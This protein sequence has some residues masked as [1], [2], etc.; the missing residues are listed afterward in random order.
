MAKCPN[1]N[2]A[3]YKAL[4]EVYTSELET[5]NIINAWQSANSTDVFPT[6]VEAARFVSL[7]KVAFALKQRQFGES[8]IHNLRRK[9]LIHLYEGN[10]VINNSY[11]NSMVY[12]ATALAAN[13]KAVLLYLK[14]NNIPLESVNITRT[15][16]SYKIE[17]LDNVFTPKDIMESSR[18]WNTPRSREVV[19][20][21]MK[22]FPQLKVKM[23]S[24]KEAKAIHDGL[25]KWKKTSGPFSEVNSFYVDGVV[26]L[27][28]GKVTNETAI[29][30]MLHPFIDAIKVDNQALFNNLLAEAKVNFPEMAQQI[31][32][33]YNADRN[34]SQLDRDL[35]IVTQ[36]LTRHFNKEY[37]GVKPTKTF[38]N[39]IQD[40]LEWLQNVVN[41][42]HEYIAG[43]PLEVT[44]INSNATFS[45]IARLLN[46]ADLQFVLIKKASG[47]VRYSLSPEKAAIKKRTLSVANGIQTEVLN[48]MYR[49][50]EGSPKVVDSLSVSINS[51]KLK[52]GDKGSQVAMTFNAEEHTY[53]DLNSNTVYNSVTTAIKGKL[54]N[55]EGEAI[56]ARDEAIKGLKGKALAA[57]K[58]LWVEK[59]KEGKLVDK[60]KLESVQYNL[61][62]GNDV[63][64]IVEAIVIELNGREK[65]NLFEDTIPNMKV[66]TRDQ[67]LE[68]F[69]AMREVIRTLMPDGS[70]AM[71]QV[72][73][74]DEA[75]KLAGTADLLIVDKQGRISILDLKTSKNSILK[76]FPTTTKKGLQG[77]TLYEDKGWALP[78]DSLLKQKGV[79]TLS[80]KGQHNLQVNLYRRMLE[81]M[82]YTVNEGD[83]SA[84]T[85]HMHLDIEGKGK[86]QKYLGSYTNEKNMHHNNELSETK[87]SE[88][89]VYVD[90]LIPA[91]KKNTNKEKLDAKIAE[92]DE[93]FYSGKNDPLLKDEVI[94]ETV[95]AKVLT[96]K[97][98]IYDA[99]ENYSEAVR[100]A[101]E[102]DTNN[103]KKVFSSKTYEQR[104]DERANEQAYILSG[105][106]K[107]PL[108]Q[109]RVYTALLRKSLE[110]IREFTTYV[111]DP[112]NIDDPAYISYVLNFNRFLTT[113]APLFAIEDSSEL[114][115]TQ[116]QL[117]LNL[118]LETNKLVGTKA[119]NTGKEGL[120]NDAIFNYV[121]EVVRNKSNRQ[122]GVEGSGNT[123]ADLIKELT[124]VDDISGVDL[125]TRDLATS[126]DTLLAIVDKIYKRQKQILLDKINYR[127]S[128]IQKAGNKLLKLSPGTSKDQLYDFMHVFREGKRTGFYTKPIGQKYYTLRQEL[129][130]AT[131]DDKGVPLQY[132]EVGNFENATKE[133]IDY[134]IEVA[135]KKRALT[136]FSQAERS[137]EN[138][139]RIDGKYHR[140][141]QEFQDARKKFEFWQNNGTWGT[142]HKRSNV[143][144][145]KEV[146][147]QKFQAKYYNSVDYNKAIWLNGEPTGQVL[148]D[149]TG[150]IF[151]KGEYIVANEFS[152]DENGL[153]DV[154]GDMRSEQYKAIFDPTKTDA[155]SIAQREF[156]ELYVK[157]YEVELLGKLPA[158]VKAQMSGRIPT[159]KGELLSDLK[160][161]SNVFVRMY[162]NTVRSVSNLTKETAIQKNV[163]LDEQGNFVNSMPVFYTG[164]PRKE[165]ALEEAEA[166]EKALKDKYKKG[167]INGVT[168]KKE[169]ALLSGETAKLRS[170]PL[171]EELSSDLASSLI[172]FSAM[173][174]HYEVMGEI[175]DTLTAITRVVEN[176]AYEPSKASTRLVGRAANKVDQAI[177][178]TVGFKKETSGDSNTVRRLRKYLSMVYYDNELITKGAVDKI[179]DQLIGFSS[180]AYVAFNP[181]GNFN[182]Y[183][184]G[185]INNNIEMLGSRFYSKKSYF[186]AAKEY[187]AVA[188]PGIIKR[189]G[190]G[191][192]DIADIAT[193]GLANIG[194]TD[195]DP[196]QANN[197]YEALTELFRMMDDSTDIRES[198]RGK[199]DKGVWER[200]K[201][202]GYVL[203]DAA[204]YNVQTKVGIAL[205]MDTLVLNKETGETMSL[206]DAFKFNGKTHEVEL[207]DGFE[208]VIDKNGKEIAQ[209]NDDFRYKLRNNI[210]EVNKQIHGNYA[211]EDRM[212]IQSH[213]IGNLA[214]QFKKWVAP[215]V[216]A[217]FQNEYFDENLGWMEGRYK[218][219]IAFAAFAKQQ[220]VL[221]NRDFKKYGEGFL[222]EQEGYDGTGG[223]GDSRGQN[224]L[225]GVYRT[226][227]EIAIIIA[228]SGIGTILDSVL[229][230]DD[231]DSDTERRLKNLTKYQAD[232]LYKE[233]IL[234]A[235]ITP[236]SWVQIHQMI[237]SPVAASR[238]LGELGEAV[239]QSI[240]FAP[241]YLIK[242]EEGF[243]ADSDYV[244]QN[245][246]NK[247]K[248]K[249]AKAW[250]DA[251][252]ILTSFK[253]WNNALIEREF[254]Y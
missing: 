102:A 76:K 61:D 12:D 54:T 143:K 89:G 80:T 199:D 42:L 60:T 82:G 125:Q 107:G 49:I 27:I 200:F 123:E 111:S 14:A 208:T 100:R 168:Y 9:K 162:S 179:A 34:F 114:N 195:Y 63:D 192:Q 237:K 155:L 235:P 38:L 33:A 146:E 147:Y 129:M 101:Q 51:K 72:V 56:Q 180:L 127:E 116:K 172:K 215:A 198:Q 187:N 167:E 46:T 57:E 131:T 25:P 148:K 161:K 223:L 105:M 176:R 73:L 201:A 106:N 24:V 239:N 242:G 206:Y 234:F 124:Q 115:A 151:V 69:G 181:F 83:F 249:V 170:A 43:N 6:T 203:Q 15:P 197:K 227:G 226:M 230:G 248:L 74:F 191:I 189:T 194:K 138:G 28:Q 212:I 152:L 205:I 224:R 93:S 94:P 75:T 177:G 87:P 70:I 144:G 154:N 71:S 159:V 17:V 126:T 29:E 21:L 222:K 166:K 218:S 157:Y 26:Y 244:Y 153:A 35:E 240:W 254:E 225:F 245:K 77:L 196:N 112:K 171:V 213:T 122:F 109:S 160:N 52:P 59:I 219:A 139:N 22:M 37:N 84:T 132:R 44:A 96:E 134:N 211:A 214:A 133:D 241:A 236:D 247:G 47:K 164:S 92:Q 113:F 221:G 128:V 36:A 217:R 184:M 231:D 165:G 216:R 4:Q 186:R 145:A 149:K 90:M 163:L 8:V 174:E 66:L 16:K 79:D 5:N 141:N 246:P 156:Y 104:L 85:F 193:L 40:A 50:V 91:T 68:M 20:H 31:T 178:G 243:Y 121:K 173:A 185:K 136:N 210:R 207:M 58:K 7:N 238:M 252:P 110:R 65:M 135:R 140:Y 2:T 1:K 175:E 142:W 137:D 19:M 88:N 103:K 182:N 204:E 150:G 108:E 98:T 233:L 95:E 10:Y 45:D 3:E 118:Q 130:D 18:A 78:A 209:Y 188:L 158:S 48:E 232:R 41:N 120:I 251:L 183:L 202:W 23:L 13:H 253:K 86:D 99:V 190:A 169:A 81:N 228:V 97:N 119:L 32:D 62:I 64:T 11:N 220:I 53:M 67:T 117:V 229:A 30:E 39:L 250:E 55:K